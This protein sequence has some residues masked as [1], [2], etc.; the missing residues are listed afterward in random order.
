[1]SILSRTEPESL[2][3]P[4]LRVP[5][6]WV[7]LSLIAGYTLA[8]TVITPVYHKPLAYA[9]V[10]LAAAVTCIAV[11]G[12]RAWL[13]LLILSIIAF[14]VSR[15]QMQDA[16]EP[17]EWADLPARDALLEI[18]VEQ[19][20]RS[21]ALPER[22][23][24][25][26]RVMAT[27]HAP[28]AELEGCRVYYSLAPCSEGR[29]VRWG[30]RVK[31]RGVVEFRASTEPRDGFDTYLDARRVSATL[32]RG[33]VLEHMG[34]ASW[35]TAFGNAAN[36]RLTLILLAGSEDKEHPYGRVFAAMLLGQKWMLG[37]DLRTAFV[38]T[39]TM[40]LF[41][42]SGL[43]VAAVALTLV[44]ALQ[45]MRAPPRAAAVTGLTLLFGYVLAV[46]APP[47]AVRAFSMVAFYWAANAFLRQ[48][49]PLAA[50]VASAVAVLLWDP[51]QLFAVGFQ[52]S[53]A[54]VGS[55]LLIG[56]PLSVHLRDAINL[57][58]FMPED[59]HPAWVAPTA[60]A[61]RWTATAFSISLA[62]SLG[63]MPLIIAYFDLFTP[64]ALLLNLALI[65]AASLAVVNGVISAAVGLAGLEGLSAFLNRG[66]WT[67]LAVMLWMVE[68]ALRVPGF[69]FNMEWRTGA[70]PFVT[71]GA[72]LS[73][74][75]IIRFRPLSATPWRFALPPAVFLALLMFGASGIPP[76]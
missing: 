20:F 42:V 67:V 17:A 64:G 14:G 16:P 44:L 49:E 61:L 37:P 28:S 25:L 10:A 72:I 2:R 19:T 57:G 69:Y 63:S 50:L 9:L 15:W 13:P 38:R 45:L 3:L 5:L 58:R 46:G 33:A 54:V 60:A 68:T 6:V 32:R 74:G 8:T 70:M 51:R 12:S 59:L 23:M 34:S 22:A 36:E 73:S 71:V 62:A 39:G 1:M 26:G 29:P 24:G 66:S 30:E 48:R 18:H 56:L 53:Y 65:P 31:A 40:H 7:L 41:A 21:L 52:L 43:H 76:D 35:H 27:A 55:I 11:S 4:S 75:V 47:S